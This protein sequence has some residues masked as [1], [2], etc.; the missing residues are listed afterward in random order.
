MDFVARSEITVPVAE[1]PALEQAFRDRARLVDDHPGFVGLQLLRDIRGN[2]RYVLLT[3]WHSRAAFKAYMKSG[4]HARAHG[5]QHEGL[6]PLAGA[7]PLEQFD[8]VIEGPADEPL[9]P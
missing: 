5:R 4:D 7:G 8:V 3:R 6:G 1:G 2:G 9:Q